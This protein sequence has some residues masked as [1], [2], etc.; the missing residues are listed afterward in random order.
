MLNRLREWWESLGRNNQIVLV[1]SSLGGLVALIGFVAWASTPEYVPLFSNLG[2]A[3][4]TAITQKLKD[5][6]VPY[7]LNSNG[8]SIEV[9]AQNHDEMQMT[10][11][12]EG[13]PQQANA[14]PGYELLE[15]TNSFSTQPMEALMMM[16]A[17]EGEIAK[18]I[19]TMQQISSATV[20]FANADDTPFTRDKHDASASIILAVKPGQTL[21][22]E[23]VHAIVRLTQMSFTG[24]NEKS[25]SVVDGQG[26]LLFDGTR[27]TSATGDEQMKRQHSL[28][29]AK[30]SELQSLLD[31]TIGPHKAVVLV[32]VELNSDTEAIEKTN[33]EPGA[34]ISQQSDNEVLNG[35]GVVRGNALGTGANVAGIP[36]PAGGGAA[37]TIPTYASSNATDGKYTHDTVVKNLQPSLTHTNITKAPG[38]V[39]KLTVSALVDTK[40]P[41]AQVASITEVLKTA[42]GFDASDVNHTR[43]VTVAQ[44]PFDRSAED[45]ESKASAAAR[46]SENTARMVSI[47][48][49]LGLMALCLFLLARALRKPRV[50]LAGGQLALAGG[51]T[52]M[53]YSLD[54]SGQMMYAPDGTPLE[55]LP[56]GG[57]YN[58]LDENG[59]IIG[60]SR[61]SGPKTYEVISENFDAN[62]ESILHLTKSKP[63]TVALLIASWISE[64]VR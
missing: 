61:S 45:A 37:P 24:L 4:A 17:K 60:L 5:H 29:Q 9:P 62:L 56:M 7:K 6:N 8:T 40:V 20:H 12:G 53:G 22:D 26:D 16:R 3:D 21:S 23:N 55:G 59:Q 28:A 33:Y 50:E 64:D 10:L 41:A 58:S 30:R 27:A 18:S 11:V 32:N 14:T 49:P 15:K 25:I 47:F 36:N 39:E 1:A 42:I 52:G 13:L 19:M 57:E 46:S 63:E 54:G 34:V 43:S 35:Q 2:A 51:G 44:V 38:R 48:V 31:T